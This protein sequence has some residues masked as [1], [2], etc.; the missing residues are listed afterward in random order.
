MREPG[1]SVFQVPSLS[2]PDP[3]HPPQASAL[4]Q[5]EAV[6]L[7]RDRAAS[8]RTGFEVTARNAS[9][10]TSICHR[11]DGI[12]LAL[13]LAAAR[14][15]AMSVEQIAARLDDRFRLLTSSDRTALPRQQTLRA[16]IDW[17]YDLLTEAE[18][19]VLQRLAVFAGGWTLEAAEAIGRGGTIEHDDVLDLLTR[20][21]EKS[22]VVVEADGDRYRL[23]ETVQQYAAERLTQASDEGA[24]RERH[25]RYYLELAEKTRPELIGPEQ[26]AALARLDDERENL[27]AAHAW[28]AHAADGSTLGLRLVTATRRYWMLRGLLDLGWRV[29][30]EAL[31][32]PGAD[33]R[34]LA[35]CN[36]LFDVGQIGSWMGRYAESQRYLEESLSI[37]REL[38]DKHAIAVVLQPLAITELGQGDAAAARAHLAEGLALAQELGNRREV[39]AALNALAQLHR[40]DGDLAAAQPLLRDV[41]AIGRELDDR[42]IIAIGLLNLAMALIGGR[43]TGDARALLL[44][45]LAIARQ[46][47]SQPTG[48][49]ALEVCAGLAAS[50]GDADQAA[51]FYGA[52]QGQQGQTGLQRDPADE[53][54]L[55]PLVESAQATLGAERFAALV[56]AA[57]GLGYDKAL[58]EAHAWLSGVG[59]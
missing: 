18:R 48:L 20:L 39:A 54:F 4:A 27:L 43:S 37:A 1:E 8:V 58:D 45:A 29:T 55:A 35:R 26:R 56:S 10:I 6:R 23:L 46:T 44:E 41:V 51:R 52:A 34:S 50:T 42:Q 32:R 5:Y 25:L 19:L 47:G 22:L 31:S 14:V 17:S 40:Q 21:V 36:A 3:D 57:H 49:S 53:A 9:A 33:S 38:G 28:C 7:F 12:P 30:L 2:V 24:A 16:L 11:L 13:E 15:R 59:K